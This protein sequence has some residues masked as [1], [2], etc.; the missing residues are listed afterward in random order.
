MKLSFSHRY[1]EIKATI[2]CQKDFVLQMVLSA[3]CY[4][5]LILQY[6]TM[7]KHRFIIQG[8]PIVLSQRGLEMLIKEEF[9]ANALMEDL[10]HTHQGP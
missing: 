1:E 8:I 3:F 5:D 4:V 10:S 9:D 7:Y 6:H 2:F